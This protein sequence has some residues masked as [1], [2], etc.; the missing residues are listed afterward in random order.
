MWNYNFIIPNLVILSLLLLFYFSQRRL[1]IN[2]NKSFLNLLLIEISTLII[3]DASSISLDYSKS[4]SNTFLLLINILFFLLFITRGFIFYKYTLDILKIKFWNH[5]VS[6]I[7]SLVIYILTVLFVLS[8]IFYPSIFSITDKRYSRA[9]FYNTIYISSFYFSCISMVLICINKNIISKREYHFAILFNL[10]LFVGYIIRIIFKNLLIMDLFCII[11]IIIIYEIFENPDIYQDEKT[12]LFNKYALSSIFSECSIYDKP[13]IIGF[14]IHNYIDLREIYSSQQMDKVLKII[15]DYLVETYPE[16]NAFYL[17]DGRFLLFSK[18]V[19]NSI[20]IRKQLNQRF[21]EPW[22]IDDKTNIYLD[23]GFIKVAPQITIKDSNKLLDVILSAMNSMAHIGSKNI[24][25]KESTLEINKQ[26]ADVKKALEYTIENNKVEL[27]LQPLIDVKTNAV[28]GAEALA[29]I[30]DSEGRIIS[31]ASF[32]PI[33]EKNGRIVQLGEQM[34]EKTCQ[35]I[36]KYDLKS[37]GLSWINVNLSPVQFLHQ[38]LSDRFDQIL[39]NYDIPAHM[40]HLEITEE[41]MIDY[42]LLQKQIQIMKHSGFQ[43]VLDDYGTGYSNVTRL[44]KCPFINVKL[45][46]EIVWD[47][48]KERDKILPTLVETFKQMNF[49]VTAEGIEN[50]E[51]AQA[52]KEI[53]C[54]YLQGFCF[55]KPLPA[56]EFAQKYSKTL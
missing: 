50:L 27:F 9:S 37:M 52:M 53:G 54:D 10:M 24:V 8:N 55:S 7:I 23:V 36:N 18:K 17:R 35:F 6:H 16:L 29:R 19:N 45:D 34:L 26:N 13:F 40:I 51:M 44:K 20:K 22:D 33:A 56:E 5:K 11:S 42:A 12:Q 28:V 48:F 15:S 2:L 3:D 43:F 14:V 46:M 41:S 25:I 49:T 47:Y 21:H 32:I 39:R 30:R 31:P 1:P 38:N 4:F